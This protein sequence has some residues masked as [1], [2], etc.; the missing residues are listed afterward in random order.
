MT[1]NFVLRV[2]KVV[3]M[4]DVSVAY[5]K[6]VSTGRASLEYGEHRGYT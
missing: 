2:E 6:E 4:L 1:T 5:R 3:S